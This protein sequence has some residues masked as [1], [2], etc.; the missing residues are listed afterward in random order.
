MWY[1][2]TMK[3]TIDR[4]G[5]VVLPKALRDAVGIAEGATLEV[6][7]RDGRI[8]EIEVPPA[9]V[10]LEQHGDVVVAVPVEKVPPLSATAVRATL[11]SVRT[12]R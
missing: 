7:V 4:A 5:R 8:I 3:V 11:A 2:Q 9:E 12:D 1:S 10:R 6:T